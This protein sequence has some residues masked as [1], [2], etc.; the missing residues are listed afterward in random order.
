MKFRGIGLNEL[1]NLGSQELAFCDFILLKK[2]MK[3]FMVLS[4]E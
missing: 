2:K 3:P 4:K 1:T